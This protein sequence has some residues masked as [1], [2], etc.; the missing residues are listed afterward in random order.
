MKEIYLDNSMASKPSKKAVSEMMPYLGE[1][2][3]SPYS[4]HKLGE[5]AQK[6]VQEGFRSLYSSLKANEQDTIVFTSSGAEAVNQA[7]LS[8]YLTHTLESGRNQFL[9]G[10][11]D[12]AAAIMSLNRLKDFSCNYKLIGPNKQG[13]ITKEAVGNALT[14]RT[15]LVSLS[16]ANGLTGVINPISQI[17]ELLKERAILFHVDATHAIGKLD[18]DLN[19]LGVHFLSFGGETIHAPFG[20]GALYIKEGLKAAPFIQGGVEQAHLR[21]GPFSVAMLLA[22]GTCL[23]EAEETKMILATETARLR[24][25]LEDL[26]IEK[27]PTALP[28]YQE[29]ERLPHVSAIAFPGVTAETLLW[30]LNEEGVYASIGGGSLQQLSLILSSAGVPKDLAQAALS[31]SLSRETTQED[32]ENAANIIVKCVNQLLPLSSQLKFKRGEE[33]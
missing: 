19:E 31:F 9:A 24:N 6:G 7:I 4:P 16:L 23:R 21:G 13:L 14:P 26:I 30:R 3:G 27:L 28:F 18:L 2:F 33:E 8:A 20:A 1:R 5:K 32:I 17:S 15:A 11:N 22:L 12:E 25:L 10:A 29:E